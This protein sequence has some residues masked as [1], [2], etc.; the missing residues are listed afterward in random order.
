MSSKLHYKSDTFFKYLI[1][2][3]TKISTS[4]REFLVQEILNID[5]K[6]SKIQNPELS[7]Q[8]IDDKK[9]ILDVLSANDEYIVDIEMQT[10]RMSEYLHKR[11]QYYSYRLIT[12][13]IE[14]GGK[15]ID[16]RN[17]S[18]IVFINDIHPNNQSLIT[19]LSLHNQETK[20]SYRYGLDKIIFVHMPYIM[21][22]AKEKSILSEFEAVIYLLYNDNLNGIE[23]N[24]EKGVVEM[25]QTIFQKFIRGSLFKH[26]LSRQE[27]RIDIDEWFQSSMEESRRET[28]KD[29]LIFLVNEKYHIDAKEW[30]EECTLNQV[31]K[32][33]KLILSQI[34]YEDFKESILKYK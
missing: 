24:N 6:L 4:I 21:T 33:L 14:K 20:K 9:A 22:I 30:I 34:S 26:A 29:D 19:T 5:Y 8:S 3:Q 1:G 32:G 11:F 25:I 2:R 16:L 10:S 13:Q 27:N 12:E 18:L 15:Y 17:V 31:K 7:P 28:R 23:W